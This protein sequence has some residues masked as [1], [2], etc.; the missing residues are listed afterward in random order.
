[1][2]DVVS[3]SPLEVVMLMWVTL[4]KRSE[5]NAEQNR[6]F[7]PTVMGDLGKVFL[8]KLRTALLGAREGGK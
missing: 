6:G 2:E 1:M 3:K 5:A 4:P 8:T 7:K